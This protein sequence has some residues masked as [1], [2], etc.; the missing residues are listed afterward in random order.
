MDAE[1]LV[2][3]ASEGERME[4]G[5]GELNWKVT[6]SV[7]AGAEMTLGTCYI[8]S[9]ERN[10]LHSHPNCE[11]FLHV[12]S[13]VCEHRLDNVTV[14]LKAG[15][16]IRIPRNIKH[17]AR[18]IGAEPLLALIMFSSGKRQAVNHEG[19]GSGVA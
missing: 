19:D 15:D 11:E 6:D 2:A 14:T 13:G 9:G 5:W 12:L 4:T 7:M 16:T 18:A 1:S 17:W 8:K 10:Q 3:R